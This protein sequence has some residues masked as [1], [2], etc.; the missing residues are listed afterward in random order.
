MAQ[1]QTIS[2]TSDLSGKE[3][4]DNDA[5]TIRYAWDGVDYEV[6]LT[7]DEAEKMHAA[8][9]KYLSVSR[10]VSRTTGTKRGGSKAASGPSAA[11]IRAWA[12]SNGHEVPDRGRIPA[13]VREAFEAAS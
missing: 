7:S 5:P 8:L 12:Q 1:S 11:E 2:Y 6:D 10:K 9:E 3:I 4:K 13:A